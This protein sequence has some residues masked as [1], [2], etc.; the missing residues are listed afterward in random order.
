MDVVTP[1]WVQLADA[2]FWGLMMVILAA[3]GMGYGF[4]IYIVKQWLASATETRKHST[5]LVAKLS[6]DSNYLQEITLKAL[7]DNTH[8]L[9]SIDKTV[10][11]MARVVEQCPRRGEK[12]E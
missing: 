7:Q 4:I 3:S 5:E 2:K 6:Q 12:C 8:A 1:D 11:H 10:E 9:T